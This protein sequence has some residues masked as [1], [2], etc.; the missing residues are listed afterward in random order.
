MEKVNNVD[1][2]CFVSSVV[3]TVKSD[4]SVKIALDSRKLNDS[5]IKMRPPMPNMDE[6]LNQISIETTRDRTAQ[7]FL[8][9]IDLDYAY[10]QTQFVRKSDETSRQC[11]FA[12]TGGNFSGYYRFKKGFYGLADIPTIFP[13]KIDRTLDYCTPAW[14][15]DIIVV[16]RGK[17]QDHEKKLFDILNELEKAG[18]RANKRKSEFFMNR[19]KWLGHEIDEN[20]IKPNEEKIETKLKL[21]PPENTKELKSYLGAI[22]YMAK[23]LPKFL[24]QTD[25]LKKF[26][27]KNE[28]WSWGEEQQ[29]DF[30]KLKQMLTEGPCLAHYAKD[31]DNIVTTD[32]STTGFGITLWQKQDDGNTKPMYGVWKNYDFTY[33]K[34]KYT[35]IQT[36]NH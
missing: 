19:T 24:E 29:K 27:K 17:K 21:N 22:Q 23:F 35:Y 14:L 18:Y 36:T 5:C 9:K 11:V 15:D 3:K 30:K 6:L 10:G 13:E 16:T 31:K 8:S 26:L 1:E 12:L 7:P 2:D 32:A 33:T 20:G 28:P 34:R 25:R 4:K